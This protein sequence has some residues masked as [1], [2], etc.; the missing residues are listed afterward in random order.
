MSPLSLPLLWHAPTIQ[1]TYHAM[2]AI[3]PLYPVHWQSLRPPLNK[4]FPNFPINSYAS[5]MDID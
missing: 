2:F 5:E 4:L 1:S 3:L